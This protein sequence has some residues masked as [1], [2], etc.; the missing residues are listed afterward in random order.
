[1]TS[2]K[3]ETEGSFPLVKSD[4]YSNPE[5]ANALQ[6]SPSFQSHREE[7][8]EGKPSCQPTKSPISEF[9]HQTNTSHSGV[10]IA[11]PDQ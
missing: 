5:E 7:N 11:E 10:F 3:E 6:E 4:I 2:A 8:L 1:M 9:Q